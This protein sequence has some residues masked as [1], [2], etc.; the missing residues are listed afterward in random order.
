MPEPRDKHIPRPIRIIS[1][2]VDE[3]CIHDHAFS[4]H[5]STFFFAHLHHA[6]AFRNDQGQMR[7]QNEIREIRVWRYAGTRGLFCE[8]NFAPVFSNG[9]TLACGY[10]HA[11]GAYAP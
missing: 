11:C 8:E 9:A 2:G 7:G 1:G 6:L 3:A 4:F 10:M 5:P